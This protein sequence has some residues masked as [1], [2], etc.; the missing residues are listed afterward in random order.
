MCFGLIMMRAH[1][2]LSLNVL[3]C[4]SRNP[5]QEQ[6]QVMSSGRRFV[7]RP[8]QHRRV[9]AAGSFAE[10]LTDNDRLVT[11]DLSV[12]NSLNREP[13]EA[14][15]DTGRIRVLVRD[16]PAVGKCWYVSA[17]HE[18]VRG[19]SKDKRE[20]AV[21][22]PPSKAYGEYSTKL[23]LNHLPWELSKSEGV[24]WKENMGIRLWNGQRARVVMVDKGQNYSVDA[25][26]M[27]AGLNI[28][29]TARFIEEEPGTVLEEI[30]LAG[31]GFWGLELALAR[32]SGIVF[33]EVGYTQGRGDENNPP[34]YASVCTG[35]TDYVEAVR[36]LFD[37]RERSLQSILKRFWTFHDPTQKGMQRNDIGRQYR[38]GIYYL[39]KE[40][41]E[42]ALESMAREA[43]I[44]K[45]RLETEL[46]PANMFLKAENTHQS[47]L[48]KVSN[49]PSKKGT[50][51]LIHSY[52]G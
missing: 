3:S 15:F 8:S 6:K 17:I 11:V 42:I 36:I 52:D 46:L 37:P 44:I 10:H 39:T 47:H 41:K 2:G 30:Q 50:T 33:T 49:Q 23:V 27:N 1:L 31:G 16:S 14:L 20:A 45:Q 7:H 25:N 28:L 32:L 38:S 29:L 4:S 35:T 22:I 12:S 5:W 19:L 51:Q 43:E 18:L 48:E 9:G 24:K 13:I 21:I 34:H 26:A 40:Q